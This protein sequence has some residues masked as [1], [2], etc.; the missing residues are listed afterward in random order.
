MRLVRQRIGGSRSK[1]EE[2]RVQV[3]EKTW[4]GSRRVK[5]KRKKQMR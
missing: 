1:T 4:V 2:K 3:E 5:M